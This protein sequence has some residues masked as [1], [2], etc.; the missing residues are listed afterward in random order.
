M[1]IGQLIEW[2]IMGTPKNG[3]MVIFDNKIMFS[4]E[5]QQQK[6][7]FIKIRLLLKNDLILEPF[8]PIWQKWQNVI[9]DYEIMFSIEKQQQ[10]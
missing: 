7:F 8:W 5:K 9:F 1:A 6:S 10:K 3:K 2:P 4:M